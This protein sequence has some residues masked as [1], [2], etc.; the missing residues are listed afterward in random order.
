MT[1]A[2]ATLAHPSGPIPVVRFDSHF[3]RISDFV[4]QFPLDPSRG[5]L[6]VFTHWLDAG[7]AFRTAI[8]S[9]VHLRIRPV[10]DPHALAFAA[11][12]LYPPKVICTGVNYWDH[13]REDM[14]V[15]DFDKS[16]HDILYFLKHQHAV[17]GAADS[18]R[19]PSQSRQ[20]DWEVELVV[21]IGKTG[22]RIAVESALQYVAGYA[23]GLDLSVRDWQ[24]N[25]RH[26]KGFDL[27]AGKSFDDS[28]PLGPFVVPATYV[29]PQDL[30]LKLWVN[31][32][33]KQDS[34]TRE[35][36]WSIEEQIA[37]LSQHVTLEA[38]DAI[39]TGSPAGIGY[40]RGTFLKVGDRVEAEI[41][42]LGRLTINVIPDLDAERAMG[43]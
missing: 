33:L 23:I 43:L 13:L 22:R 16:S 17:V 21:I 7:R 10:S 37:A 14:K 42:G 15:T 18:V 1:Y 39:F 32:D 3:Y 24:F 6:D 36:I 26:F 8:D 25:P 12:I 4:P 5:L 31:G 11:P 20:L 40:V 30:T 27:M 29:N 38:G 19:Y 9:K 41:A 35:M 34:H 28:S 2:L